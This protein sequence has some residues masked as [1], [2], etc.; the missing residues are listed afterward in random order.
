MPLLLLLGPLGGLTAFDDTASAQLK[1]NW[2]VAVVAAVK[3]GAIYQLA[4]QKQSV[5]WPVLWMQQTTA[6]EHVRR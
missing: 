1:H 5:L 3:L 4:L 2:I 6:I